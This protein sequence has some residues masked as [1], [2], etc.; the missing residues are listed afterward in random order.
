MKLPLKGIIPPMVT[1]LLENKELDSAGLKNLIEYLLE[2]RVHGIFLL[3][4]NGEGPS[5]GY[6]LRKQL[7]TEACKIVDHRV[8]VLVG[9][10][11]TSFEAVSYTHLRAHETDSYLV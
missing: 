8:P 9:I 1:P 3:G 4:T 10:T 5:L 2:G 7:I 6:G 11:D